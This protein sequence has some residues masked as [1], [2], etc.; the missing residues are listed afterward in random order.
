MRFS[1]KKWVTDMGNRMTG[2][3]M[4]YRFTLQ[5]IMKSKSNRVVFGILM[6]AAALT[7]PVAGLFLGSRGGGEVSSY[8]D[9][10]TVEEYLNGGRVGFDTRHGIQYGYSIVAM[11]ICV[12]SVTYIV[13]TIVEEKV[14]RLVETLMVSVR[15]MALVLGKILAVMTFMFTMLLAVLGV[16]ALSYTISGRL[17]DVSFVSHLLASMGISMEL[18]R[19]GPGA[20]LVA[21]VSLVL[22][23]CFFS[24]LAGLAGAGCSNMDEIESANMSAMMAIL[25]GYLVSCVGFGFSGGPWTMVMAI[26]PVVSAFTVPAFYVFGD[27]GMGVVAASWLVELVCVLMLLVLSARVYDQLILYRG[28]RLKFRNVLAMGTGHS[29]PTESGGKRSRKG[30]T[31]K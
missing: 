12:F 2:A 30:G 22:A 20:L 26:C 7:I 27:I 13:R 29:I 1:W 14:S 18:L 8:V 5:Q 28:S 17:M 23:Y 16:F 21:L 25:A 15:P 9:V 31:A 19:L 24:L 11:I 3:G 10:S 4:V 6:A